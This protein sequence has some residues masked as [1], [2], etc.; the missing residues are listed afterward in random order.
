MVLPS[1]PMMM[2]MTM[3]AMVLM[4]S[5]LVVEMGEA[6]LKL[7]QEGSDEKELH[8][9]KVY[10]IYLQKKVMLQEEEVHL[11]VELQEKKR[12]VELHQEKSEVL[13][14]GSEASSLYLLMSLHNV[15]IT[16]ES[17]II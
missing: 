6:A 17:K 5:S 11:V 14:L 8:V 1:L 12:L 13:L 3:L 9:K 4:L 16:P 10:L 7:L 15:K 2:M